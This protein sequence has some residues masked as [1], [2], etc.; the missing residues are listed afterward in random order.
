MGVIMWYESLLHSGSKS[1]FDSL[2]QIT[3][4]DMRLLTYPWRE[5]KQT[6]LI[7]EVDNGVVREFGSI[8]YHHNGKT[9]VSICILKRVHV[10]FITKTK[11]FEI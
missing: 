7:K 2:I 11:P 5:Q 6:K 1:R 10:H 8:I 3:K 9:C 4:E